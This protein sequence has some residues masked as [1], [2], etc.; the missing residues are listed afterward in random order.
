[1]DAIPINLKIATQVAK[2]LAC[3]LVTPVDLVLV[4]LG[5]YL[6]TVTGTPTAVQ[7]DVND[8]GTEITGFGTIGLGATAGVGTQVKTPHLGGAVALPAVIAAGSEI[9]IDLKFSAG[10]SP[11]AEVDIV[12]WVLPGK[13]G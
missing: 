13:K 8:D 2:N 12:L 6:A 3:G 9:E 10:T 5:A 11:T 1:M 4:G 7:I